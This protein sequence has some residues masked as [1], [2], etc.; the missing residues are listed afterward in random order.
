MQRARV[1]YGGGIYRRAIASRARRA[2]RRFSVKLRALSRGAAERFAL[3][4]RPAIIT[5]IEASGKILNFLIR[6][7]CGEVF[8][9]E[10]MGDFRVRVSAEEVADES[11]V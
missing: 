11:I 3:L 4:S 8:V 9:L 10:R 1:I 2:S 6:A 7:E 5:V